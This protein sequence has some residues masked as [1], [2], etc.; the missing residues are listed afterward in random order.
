MG[1]QVVRGGLGAGAAAGPSLV[2]PDRTSVEVRLRELGG[3]WRW[4]VDPSKELH[5]RSRAVGSCR[6]GVGTAT[7]ERCSRVLIVK[8]TG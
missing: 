4:Q 7:L 2:L 8:A 6:K 5:A 3:K 1:A